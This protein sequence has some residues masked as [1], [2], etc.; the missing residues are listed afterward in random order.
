MPT[1]VNSA[2]MNFHPNRRDNYVNQQ[3]KILRSADDMCYDRL[4]YRMLVGGGGRG[5]SSHQFCTTPITTT[6][7][8][9]SKIGDNEDAEVIQR[10]SSLS[11]AQ[12]H[13]DSRVGGID[14]T[15]L[16]E[17]CPTSSF[18]TVTTTSSSTSS[19][20][21]PNNKNKK[22]RRYF[23]VR[24]NITSSSND[25]SNVVPLLVPPERC[26]A[27][28]YYPDHDQHGDEEE[29]SWHETKRKLDAIIQ[30]LRCQEG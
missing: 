11:F 28:F 26:S 2:I 3:P 22:R 10:Y 24:S 9:A 25:P 19:S 30:S 17:N 5:T 14:S 29:A 21:I 1:T 18:S 6:A 23:R 20:M 27:S 12:R 13:G 16:I 4:S 8:R 15:I 7:T